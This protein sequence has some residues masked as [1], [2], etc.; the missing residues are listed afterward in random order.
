L[1]NGRASLVEVEV[2]NRNRESA[3]IL[4]GLKEGDELIAYPS[5][6]IYD[7]CAVQKS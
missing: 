1:E 6:A 5:D 4:K 2:G 3:E 7:G